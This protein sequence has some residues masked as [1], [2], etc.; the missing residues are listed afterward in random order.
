MVVHR[1]TEA[2]R[3]ATVRE[4]LLR[5]ALQTPEQSLVGAPQLWEETHAALRSRVA[6]VAIRK[7][8]VLG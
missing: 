2:W 3:A 6:R 7:C 1:C 4:R 5:W 8:D